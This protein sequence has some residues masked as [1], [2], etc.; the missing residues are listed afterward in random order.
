VIELTE[1]GGGTTFRARVQPGAIRTRVVGE[2]DGALKVSVVAPAEGG[3]ANRAVCRLLA[4]VLGVTRRQV[5]IVAGQ[6]HRDK[7][8]RVNGLM[9]TELQRRLDRLIAGTAQRTRP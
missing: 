8:V 6:T 7:R 3:K 1:E 9:R 4:E 2:H 5:E